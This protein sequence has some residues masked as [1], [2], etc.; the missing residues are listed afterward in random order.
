MPFP[1]YISLLKGMATTAK[2]SAE[3]LQSFIMCN[4]LPPFHYQSRKANAKFDCDIMSTCMMPADMPQNLVAAYTIGDGNCLYN[5]LSM[6]LMGNCSR[7]T[8]LRCRVAYELVLQNDLYMDISKSCLYYDQPSIEYIA[9]VATLGT[10][11]GILEVMAA[12]NVM[13]LDIVCHYPEVNHRIRPYYNTTFKAEFRRPYKSPIHIMFT[14]AGSMRDSRVSYW[15]PNHFAII[16]PRNTVKGNTYWPEQQ[17]KWMEIKKTFEELADTVSDVVVIDDDEDSDDLVNTIYPPRITQNVN[18]LSNPKNTSDASTVEYVNDC[19][20][21][22]IT[23]TSNETVSLTNVKKHA[24]TESHCDGLTSTICPRLTRANVKSQKFYKDTRCSDLSHADPHTVNASNAQNR[25]QIESK[26]TTKKSSFKKLKQHDKT[27]SDCEASI[28]TCFPRVTRSKSNSKN[29]HKDTNCAVLLTGDTQTVNVRKERVFIESKFIENE[30]AA[31]NNFKQHNTQPKTNVE[32]LKEELLDYAKSL[33]GVQGISTIKSYTPRNFDDKIELAKCAYFS[34]ETTTQPPTKKGWGKYHTVRRNKRFVVLKRQCNSNGNTNDFSGSCTAQVFYISKADSR[35]SLVLPVGEHN[36]KCCQL[37]PTKIAYPKGIDVILNYIKHDRRDLLHCSDEDVL[38]SADGDQVFA[39][40][41]ENFTTNKAPRNRPWGKLNSYR[42]TTTIQCQVKQRLC[43]APKCASKLRY[44]RSQ[45]TDNVIV[46]HIGKHICNPLH[47]PDGRKISDVKDNRTDSIPYHSLKSFTENPLKRKS[48][49]PV[50]AEH[51]DSSS[52]KFLK[53]DHGIHTEVPCK[54]EKRK[55]DLCRRNDGSNY[56]PDVDDCHTGP[57]TKRRRHSIPKSSE[58]LTNVPALKHDRSVMGKGHGI[59]KPNKLK[60]MCRDIDNGNQSDEDPD[61]CPEPKKR[62]HSIVKFAPNLLETSVGEVKTSDG[63]EYVYSESQKTVNVIN[64]TKEYP[65]FRTAR[66]TKENEKCGMSLEKTPDVNND[67]SKCRLDISTL[68]DGD[69]EWNGSGV[70]EHELVKNSECNWGNKV[71]SSRKENKF[72]RKCKGKYVCKSGQCEG[73]EKRKRKCRFCRSEMEHNPCVATV[74]YQIVDNDITYIKHRGRHTCCEEKPMQSDMH[75]SGSKQTV[76]N[77]PYD[78]DGDVIY[79]VETDEKNKWT[80]I[81]DGRKWGKYMS[82]TNSQGNTVYQRHCVGRT[83]CMSDDCPFYRRYGSYNTAQFEHINNELVCRECGIKAQATPCKA[84]KTILISPHSADNIVV[85]HEGYHICTPIKSLKV[86]SEEIEKLTRLFPS[87]KPAV[88]SNS[89]MKQVVMQNAKPEEISEVARSLL[90]KKKVQKTKDKVRKGLFPHGTNVDAIVTMKQDMENNEHDSFLI[91][92]VDTETQM[93]FTTSKEKLKI[94]CELSGLGDEIWPTFSPYAHIDFQPSRVSG[95]SVLGVQC[96]HPNLKQTVPLFK[97]YAPNELA[98]VVEFGLTTFNEAVREFSHNTIKEFNPGG[99]MC[100]EAGSILKSLEIVYGP[101][102]HSKLVTCQAHYKFS[103]DRRKKQ[104]ADLNA[105]SRYVELACEMERVVTS[106]AYNA[107]KS[108]MISLLNDI[109]NPKLTNWL[110]WWDLR[111]RHWALAFRPT[112][113]APL[114]NLS[115][116]IHASEKARNSV[117]IQLVDAV[118]D[119]V[120]SSYMLKEKI[121]GY[122]SGEYTGGSGKSLIQ[123]SKESKSMQNIRSKAYV[124]ALNSC[125]RN[126]NSDF[127]IDPSSTH[128]EDKICDVKTGIVTEI[129]I[130]KKHTSI[131][132]IPKISIDTNECRPCKRR[133]IPSKSFQQSKENAIR[134]YHNYTIANDPNIDA[135]IEDEKTFLVL[136]K[137]FQETTE[138]YIVRISRMPECGCVYFVKN[139]GKQVCKHIIMVLLE[140]GV[141]EDDALLY[142]IGYTKSELRTLLSRDIQQYKHSPKLKTEKPSVKRKHQFYLCSYAKGSTRGPRPKCCSCKLPLQDG[143]VIEIDGKYRIQNNSFD[144][145]F[146]L[147]VKDTCLLTTPKYS[148]ISR[149]PKYINRG[150][151]TNE[152]VRE[153]HKLTSYKIM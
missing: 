135:E 26:S 106:N 17:M 14:R 145:T 70:T 65:L 48:D 99:W 148:D 46:Q 37:N 35:G 11:S 31:S 138:D 107:A 23:S 63:A 91:Y 152:N 83:A 20:T 100:D 56:S 39:I 93:V 22:Y 96:Y 5:S 7:S 110:N 1:N 30:M 130:E 6:H 49:D 3:S 76:N 143:I 121:K 133:D 79:T 90:D 117:N 40:P 128:R 67:L 82:V 141:P 126:D 12:A 98:P 71:F 129:Q 32:Q 50:F 97:L 122:K 119:D 15:N 140:L 18:P 147:H 68:L 45:L 109:N 123:M 4:P 139:H 151:S 95:M 112:N 125:S 102:V 89:I 55:R 108:N 36:T 78:I 28:N 105:R 142:Q 54:P 116:C 53:K 2:E 9:S 43:K 13:G 21:Q 24:N 127:V 77:L 59:C 61:I 41:S 57:K 33:P 58:N 115:E 10:F 62:R 81:S 144:K 134:G 38:N 132:K 34:H 111:K 153:A 80:A 94:A 60:R 19:N 51:T 103:I 72:K 114:N 66:Y 52:N 120:S 131:D 74:V 16:V 136:K 86:C 150:N 137:E 124:K 29:V 146:R 64:K 84:K 85:R 75:E 73:I 104:I 44:F 92:K 101:D 27:K 118:H 42:V 25:E 149:M 8:E 88:A 87:V 69:K 47:S 113:N